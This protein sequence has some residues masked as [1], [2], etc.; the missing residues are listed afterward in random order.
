MQKRKD[1]KGRVLKEGESYRKSDGLY[2]YRWISGNDKRNTIYCATLEGLR[3]KEDAIQSDLHEGIRT[4]VSKV[5]LNEVY[6]LWKQDKVGL[7]QNTRTNYCYMYE[8]F[9]KKDFGWK[10]IQSIRKSDVRR[11]YNGLVDKKRL[12]IATIDNVHTVLHQVFK[13]A[14]EDGY[15]RSNPSDGVPGDVKRSHNYQMPKRHALTIP[16]QKAFIGFIERKPAYYHWLPLF[17]FFL[18]TGCR[19]SE[20]VGLRWRDVDMEEGLIDINHNMVYYKRDGSKRYFAI[21][22][23]KT[24][25]GCR[26][27]PLMPEVREALLQERE[28]QR[29]REI[30]CQVTI[31]GYTD[32]IFLNRFGGPHNP[33]TINRAIKRITL[34]HNEEELEKAEKERREPIL[35]P[36]FSCHNLRH[37]FATRYC[38]NETNLKVI[39]EIMGHRDVSTTMDVY[40]EATKDAKVKSFANLTGKILIS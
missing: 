17:K 36:P 7:K 32:F 35:I 31:D 14:V 27:I 3:E 40:A 13:L 21:T 11:F 26:I 2:M 24:Q 8:H 19:V 22:T 10:K 18:G 33:S 23:P 16:Q 6:E 25:A 15:I 5:T 29:E 28:N 1:N 39:Q 4:G 37:T 38:E 34:L 9:V 12:A 20:I 30:T